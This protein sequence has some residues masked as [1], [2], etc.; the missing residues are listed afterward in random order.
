MLSLENMLANSVHLGHSVKRWNPKM[1][2][3]IYGTRNNAHIIDVLQ[4]MLCIYKARKLI[5][6]CRISGGNFDINLIFYLLLFLDIIK[7]YFFYVICFYKISVSP[8]N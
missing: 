8:Y 2:T 1:S 3:Y 4:T 5:L 7:V 6:D